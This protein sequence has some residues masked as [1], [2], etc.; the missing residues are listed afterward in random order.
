MNLNRLSV[1]DLAG[2]CREETLRFL[3][4]EPRDDLFCFELFERAVARREPQAW[5][6]IMVQYRGIVLA[7]VGQHAAA[8]VVRESEDFW[9][10]RAFQRF[11]MAVGPDRFGQ[12]RDLPGLLKYLKLCVHSVLL[13]EV[14]SRRVGLVSSLTEV[15]EESASS[16]NAEETV[17]GELAGEQLWRAIGREL[18]DESERV[19][20]YLSFARDLK[21][22]E[23]YRR[24]TELY[25][26][27]ADVYRVKRNVLERLRRSPDVRAF[28]APAESA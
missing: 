16:M 2:R 18:Q 11:W 15:P 10:N 23:I 13:D 28:L 27:V 26:S 21:P 4:G 25:E 17:V 7:Y 9:V 14:R 20:A 24:H 19:V 8:A 5:E 12:F 22:A 3:R 1:A 6:A